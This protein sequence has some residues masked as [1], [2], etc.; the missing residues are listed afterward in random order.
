MSTITQTAAASKTAGIG[1]G[2]LAANGNP[3]SVVTFSCAVFDAAAVC[4]MVFIV[5]WP[6]TLVLWY[7]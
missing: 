7:C 1:V 4:V 2:V 6:L 3:L 5:V